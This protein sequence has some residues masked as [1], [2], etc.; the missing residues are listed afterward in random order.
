MAA[1][2]A[3]L[4]GEMFEEPERERVMSVSSWSGIYCAA[5]STLL[6]L[7]SLEVC[8][9]AWQSFSQAFGTTCGGTL[10]SSEMGPGSWQAMQSHEDVRCR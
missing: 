5:W 1:N 8:N 7:D 3:S 10:T 4:V 9:V 6:L 2:P